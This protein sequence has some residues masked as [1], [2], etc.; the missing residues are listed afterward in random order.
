MAKDKKHKHEWV[1]AGEMCGHCGYYQESCADCPADRICSPD[2]K[3][4]EE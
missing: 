1:S 2:G 3:C 4:E